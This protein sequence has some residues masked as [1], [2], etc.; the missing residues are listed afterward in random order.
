MEVH[1]GLIFSVLNIILIDILLGG[2]NAVVI[3]MASRKLP[4]ASRNKAIFTGT[5]LAVM[6]R[7]VLTAIMLSLLQIPYLLFI[8]GAFLVY[9]AFKLVVDKHEDPN[10]K[11]GTSF[12]SA[13]RTIVFADLVMGLDNIL[14]IAGA[15]KGNLAL[16]V[17]GLCF[18]VPIIIW[19]SKL[20][21][22]ALD[23]LPGLIYLGGAVLAYT[24][25]GMITGEPKF[26]DYFMAH[27]PFKTIVTS[28]LIISVL[29]AGWMK[30]HG[31]S[32]RTI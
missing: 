26:S 18:S 2:D 13:V 5:F 10:I 27:P 32:S 29:F 4:P 14:G 20:I 28:I 11:A 3:A 6:L 16:V 15:S 17:G 22:T 31:E 7:V 9:I 30:N 12:F 21:L 8:G 25:A 1:D 19:G 23:H 24:A